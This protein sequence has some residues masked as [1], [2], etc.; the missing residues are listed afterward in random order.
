M[1]TVTPKL[2]SYMVETHGVAAD[3]TD[4]VVNK[5]IADLLLEGK[6][7]VAKVKELTKADAEDAQVKVKSIIADE[8]KSFKD[9]MKSFYTEM[10]GEKAEKVE[11]TTENLGEKLYES[12]IANSGD[13]RVKS[14]AEQF[15]RTRSAATWDKS[16]DQYSAKNFGGQY[17]GTNVNGLP[18]NVEMPSEFDKA[19]AGAWFRRAVFGKTKGTSNYRHA[20]LD[21]KLIEYAAHECKFVGSIGGKEYEG[22]EKLSS[23][24]VKAILDDS[25]SGGLEIVPI[26]FDSNLILTPLLHGE[27]FPFVNVINVSRRRIEAGIVNNPTLLWGTNEGTAISLFDTDGFISAFDN[28]IHVISG[29]MEL[30][31]DF[32]DDSPTT[33]GGVIFAKYGEQF[34]KE[35]DNVIANGDGTTQPEGIFNK[36]GVATVTPA[37]GAGTA[38]Q[39]NDYE[40]L[41]FGVD[42]PFLQEAGMPP[43]SRAV[44]IGSYTSYQR[45][46][47]IAV[48]SGDARRVFGMDEHSHNLFGFR[49][50]INGDAGNA[51][52]AFACLNRYR[53]YRRAGMEMN[54]VTGN[55]D[56]QLARENKIGI[57]VRGRFGGALE[58]AAAA[59][60][61]TAA[62]A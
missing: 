13:V 58:L 8:L 11:K 37:G 9:D 42:Y 19:I 12:N 51:K 22:D 49:Y 17:V 27:L 60:K 18:Y 52:I 26:E 38:P 47:G 30:G 5:A 44:F 55:T 48:G 2:K 21:R 41:M 28:N 56:W 36:S 35:L 61:I 4:E 53:M 10:K 6:L 39:I 15:N 40:G 16:H 25:T 46:R 31:E 20:E 62:Q 3:A 54:V 23:L 1:F 14:V 24:H 33:I 34:K 59:A 43:N 45:A 50:K 32:L 7:D 57:V 29:A